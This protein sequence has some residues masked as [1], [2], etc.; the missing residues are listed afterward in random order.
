MRNS[1]ISTLAGL[2]LAVSTSSFVHAEDNNAPELQDNPP[3]RYV[4]VKGD[5]LW[6][7]AKRF[8][9]DPWRWPDIWGMNKEEVH[10]PHLIYP[11]NVIVLDRSSGR[12]RLRL[13]EQGPGGL[14]EA[15]EGTN[16]G[17]TVKL[18]P[19]VRVEQLTAAAVSSIP[20]SIIEPFLTRPLIVSQNQFD[21]G[22][23]VV[24]TPESRVMSGPG[25]EIYVKGLEPGAPPVWQV[26]RP[27]K[28]LFDPVSGENL[29]FE[30]NYLGDAQIK[31]TGDVS[32]M[33]I[34]RAQREIG[35]GDRL[36]E[37]PPAE[38]LSYAPHAA[39]KTMQGVIISA[40]ATTISEIGQYQ[41]VVINLGARNGVEPGHVFALY[42]ASRLVTPRRL[43]SSSSNDPDRREI[44][45]VHSEFTDSKNTE[46]VLLPEERYGLIFVFRVFEK[47]SYA[48][49]MNLSHPANLLDIVRA[50]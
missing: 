30:V 9:K 41:I 44:R 26:Y 17:S 29:G 37:A 12:P 38:I 19:R 15:S 31:Q 50:P 27:S 39:D 8:L 11:G 6:G 36:V 2:M 33:R 16:V 40:P 23:R 32:S 22:P 28:A 45:S 13:E 42:S 24:A 4:V 47:V 20:A 25:D 14:L 18:K 5:T 1:I 21:E 34:I 49:V 48:L 43:P 46:S 10:N 3:E 7:I 35:V